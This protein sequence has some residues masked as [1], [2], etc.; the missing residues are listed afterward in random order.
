MFRNT[1]CHSWLPHF[2]LG[3]ARGRISTLLFKWDLK[4]TSALPQL[5]RSCPIFC[6]FTDWS[7]SSQNLFCAWPCALTSETLTLHHTILPQIPRFYLRPHDSTSDHRTLHHIPRPYLRL[8]YPTQDWV[9]YIT[10][11]KLETKTRGGSNQTFW[12]GKAKM[13]FR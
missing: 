3:D 9:H 5:S 11:P 7:S 10:M 12:R 4:L 13:V 1:H 8:Y 6:I 2:T